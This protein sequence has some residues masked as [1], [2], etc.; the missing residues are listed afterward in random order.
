MQQHLLGEKQAEFKTS[1]INSGTKKLPYNRKVW[2]VESLMNLANH[3]QLA[4][5]NSSYI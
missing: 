1:E 2:R 5:P 3:L 4:K